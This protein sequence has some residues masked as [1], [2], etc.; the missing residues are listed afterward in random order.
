MIIFFSFF[1]HYLDFFTLL[2]AV[3]IEPGLQLQGLDAGMIPGQETVTMF[4]ILI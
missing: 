4:L 1:P 3:V 2:V